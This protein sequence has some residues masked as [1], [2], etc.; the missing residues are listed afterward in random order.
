MRSDSWHSYPSI[1]ALGHRAITDLLTVPVCVEEKI[2]GSQFSFGVFDTYDVNGDLDGGRVLRARSKGAVL[3]V[4]APEP[5]FAEGVATAKRLMPLLNAGWTYRG[6]YLK[7]PRHNGLAY[8]RIPEQHVILFDINSGHE[9][10]LSQEEKRAEAAR[11]GLEC[12]P[13]L[14][15]GTIADI[16]EFRSY[17]KRES[18]LGGQP[19]E[20]VVVKPSGYDLFGPD[21]KVLMGKFVSE[22]FKEVQSKMWK[23]DNPTAKDVISMLGDAYTTQARWMKAVQHL[24][25]SGRIEDSPRDISLLMAEVPNDV[26]RECEHEMRDRLFEHAW[27]HLRRLLVRGLP[28]WYKD[29]LLKRQFEQEDTQTGA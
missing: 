24:R 14:H 25:E 9:V 20:G 4:D 5:M 18:I 10:Y 3:M 23:A 21:K 27:P 26:R 8:D 6:E 17:L 28:D 11:L 16:N 12:V 13:L 2:D 15:V 22:A 7:R 1:F 19:I 29:Q